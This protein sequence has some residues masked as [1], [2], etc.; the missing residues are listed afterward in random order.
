MTKSWCEYQ[1]IVIARY[2]GNILSSFLHLLSTFLFPNH[3]PLQAFRKSKMSGVINSVV[4]TVQWF[5]AN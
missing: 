3:I 4:V 2:A 5:N 1:S